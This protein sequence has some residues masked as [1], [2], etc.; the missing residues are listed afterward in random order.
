MSLHQQA[1]D[2]F[3][4]ALEHAPADRVAFIDAACG[5]DASLRAEIE[6]L[7]AFHE[8]ADQDDAATTDGS[9]PQMP[10][11][12]RT[13]GELAIAPGEVFAGRYRMISRIGR[14]GMG[15]VSRGGPGPADAGRAQADRCP[16]RARQAAHPQRSPARPSD[17]TSRRLPSL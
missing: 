6:S 7:L 9:E 5:E 16:Q 8:E 14:G 12:T 13:A 17:H 1:K 3:L 11:P 2:L 15:D 4:A 10:T